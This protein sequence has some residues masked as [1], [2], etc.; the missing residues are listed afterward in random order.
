MLFLWIS[1]CALYLLHI[2]KTNNEINNKMKEIAADTNI[3]S[4]V[5]ILFS[6]SVTE[7]FA[8]SVTVCV[9]SIV[10]FSICATTSVFPSVC[11]AKAVIEVIKTIEHTATNSRQKALIILILFIAD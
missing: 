5:E 9:V 7:A 8:S 4:P 11:V 10:Q 6:S 3:I 2:I 1:V